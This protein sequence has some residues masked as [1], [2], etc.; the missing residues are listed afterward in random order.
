MIPSLRTGSRVGNLHTMLDLKCKETKIETSLNQQRAMLKLRDVPNALK[1]LESQKSMKPF[2]RTDHQHNP[3]YGLS[4][5]LQQGLTTET[6]NTADYLHIPFTEMEQDYEDRPLM[7]DIEEQS[8]DVEK[9]KKPFRPASW[10]HIQIPGHLANGGLLQ[11]PQAA[12][13]FDDLDNLDRLDSC[14]Y[15]PPESS[16]GPGNGL[17]RGDEGL[18]RW[19]EA[20]VECPHCLR[21][22]GK[23][24]IN[25]HLADQHGDC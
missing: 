19:K 1:S 9:V 16:P 12:D 7:I 17:R 18:R 15:G 5:F 8:D 2:G 21:T 10:S 4:K 14:I 22:Y 11:V 20:R 25:K 24:Y 13:D 3:G 23:Y 6:R